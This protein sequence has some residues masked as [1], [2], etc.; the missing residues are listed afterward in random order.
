MQIADILLNKITQDQGIYPRFN[1]DTDRISLFRELMECGDVHFPPI[2]VVR[3]N[4]FYILLDGHHRL[5]AHRRQGK[6]KIRTE[7][8]KIEKRHWRL[9]AARFNNVSSKPL[10]GKELQKTIRDAWEI[11]GIRDTQ[12]IAQELNCSVQYVRR[13]LKSVKQAEKDKIKKDIV[14]LK[15][16]GLSEREIATRTGEPRTTVQRIISKGVAQN[17]TVSKW[18]APKKVAE[19][20]NTEKTKPMTGLIG[21]NPDPADNK[22]DISSRTSSDHAITV[23]NTL[24]EPPS[25][26]P[27]LSKYGTWKPGEKTCIRAMELAHAGWDVASIS[28]KLDKTDPWVRNTA[29]ALIAIHQSQT[30]KHPHQGRT[31]DQIAEGLDISDDRVVYLNEF[32]LHFPGVLPDRATIFRWL[33]NNAAPY[34]DYNNIPPGSLLDIMRLEAIYRKCLNDGIRPPWEKE[35]P[36]KLDELP[37]DVTQGFKETLQFFEDLTDLVQGGILDEVMEDLLKRYNWFII[38]VNLFQD[39]LF[40]REKAKEIAGKVKPGLRDTNGADKQVVQKEGLLA[41]N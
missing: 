27:E 40:K 35:E 6:Q 37:A 4:G 13:V 11:D 2:K 25:A 31:T 1:T 7:I 8:W 41:L 24:E 22:S 38:S 39:A 3:H 19:P 36:P 33:A 20:H 21:S 29:A 23:F 5:E 34:Q 30:D 15:K 28:R 26:I 9:A 10:T 17:E 16:E 18:A 32:V 12:E 14:E